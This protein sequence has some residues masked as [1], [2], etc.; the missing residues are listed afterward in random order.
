MLKPENGIGCKET[1][2]AEGKE[3]DGILL[4]GLFLL[5]VDPEQTIKQTFERTKYRAEKRLA[6]N[7]Q[8]LRKI[9]PNGLRQHQENP[10]KYCQLDPA[11]DIHNKITSSIERLFKTSPDVGQR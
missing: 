8:N 1:H 5:R 6:V 10:D 7:V 4:P 3:R 11:I 2:Q 9:D